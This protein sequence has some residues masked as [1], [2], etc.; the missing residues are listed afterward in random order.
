MLMIISGAFGIFKRN[1]FS[2][3]GKF[4]KDTMTEDFDLA[5]KIRKRK[6][7]IKFARDSIARTY[8]PNN[9]KAWK[10][11]RRRWA[12]GH[13]STLYKHRDMLLSS[14]FTKKD[15]VG[16]ADMWLMDVILVFVFWFSPIVFVPYL[17]LKTLEGDGHIII[18]T[19]A[20]I[21]LIYL[22]AETIIFLYAVYS[23]RKWSNLKLIYLIPV[24]AFGYRILLKFI[25]LQGYFKAIRGK[26]IG[27]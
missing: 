10:V 21:F 12:H 27:W 25:V 9:W 19:L 17:I 24:V 13:I 3:I 5:L 4:D 1:I 26:K 16:Q 23:S 7:K 2:A 20:M 22:A 8:C 6:G 14:R 18:Y 15:R 11:Q